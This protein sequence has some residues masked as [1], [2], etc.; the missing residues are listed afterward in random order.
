MLCLR[1]LHGRSGS[2]SCF[3]PFTSPS[4]FSRFFVPRRL[5]SSLLDS[6]ALAIAGAPHL[7]RF[8]PKPPPP[9]RFCHKI[10]HYVS[11][12]SSLSTQTH[13][14]T[15]ILDRYFETLPY[16]R[17]VENLCSTS[18]G[19]PRYSRTP[20]FVISRS[21]VAH[22]RAPASSN[23]QARQQSQVLETDKKGRPQADDTLFKSVVLGQ[24]LL[25]HRFTSPAALNTQYLELRDCSS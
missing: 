14:K 13:L 22:L 9:L 1:F 15:T 7:T 11:T 17:S 6:T 24:K 3:S 25:D 8:D 23:Y 2:G 20:H 21:V 18:L 4:G 16:C 19:H 12:V 10:N 5:P